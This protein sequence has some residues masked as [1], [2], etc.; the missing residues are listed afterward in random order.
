MADTAET[1]DAVP[2][3][4]DVVVVL[5]FADVTEAACIACNSGS[6]LDPSVLALLL[7]LEPPIWAW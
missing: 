3:V 5:L 7:S 6:V 2:D 4:D 1:C